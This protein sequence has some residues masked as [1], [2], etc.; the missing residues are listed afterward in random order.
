V[1]IERLKQLVATLRGK[2]GCPWDQKQTPRSMAAYLVE[3]TYELVDAIESDRPEA[4]CEELGDVLFHILF[5]TRL[6]EESGNF[7]LNAVAACI[8]EKMIRRHPHVF[9]GGSVADAEEV[10]LQWRRIKNDEKKSQDP[11]SLLDSIPPKSPA[12]M[13]AYRIS[14]RAAGAGFDWDD[15]GGVADKVE[16]EW[17]EFKAEIEPPAGE[18]PTKASAAQNRIALE[19][20]DILFTLVN[21]ARFVGIHPET[22]L[23]ASTR[24]FE[25]RF[26]L[27]EQVAAESGRRFESLSMDEMQALWQTAKTQLDPPHGSGPDAVRAGTT[28]S[29]QPS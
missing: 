19:F 22:A 23:A 7:D 9:G 28:P 25:M 15:V 16:E 17:G 18:R 24:K 5:L 14:E 1:G 29:E 3:E 8:T 12:L 21:V 6:Y 11:A 20:G 2:D 4:V 26:R 27:M 10:K 13:R